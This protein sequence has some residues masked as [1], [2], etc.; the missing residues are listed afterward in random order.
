MAGSLLAG[1]AVDVGA[2]SGVA[3]ELE[4]KSG[5]LVEYGPREQILTDPQ[6]PY[7]LDAIRLASQREVRPHLHLARRH[8]RPHGR[9]RGLRGFGTVDLADGSSLAAELVKVGMAWL[10]GTAGRETAA[11][12]K[13]ENSAREGFLGLWA[14]PEDDTDT[15][16]RKEILARRGVL[17]EKEEARKYFDEARRLDLRCGDQDAVLVDR[18][19]CAADLIDQGLWTPE[20]VRS[21]V[22]PQRFGFV[23]SPAALRQGTAPP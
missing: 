7:T 19:A 17:G 6:D 3:F 22:L 2:S 12:E 1:N 8:P 9:G 18:L 10:D 15:D 13:L 4:G 20:D 14:Y 23:P 5:K 21:E 16:W 11:L